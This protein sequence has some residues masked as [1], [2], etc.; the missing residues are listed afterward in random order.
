[1]KARKNDPPEIAI[2]M[3]AVE[4]V[5]YVEQQITFLRAKRRV[6]FRQ[7]AMA[8]LDANRKDFIYEIDKQ[9]RIMQERTGKDMLKH[10]NINPHRVQ[11]FSITEI[12]KFLEQRLIELE[13][14]KD[15]D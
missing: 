13:V 8:I 4:K 15:P 3:L 9:D 14:M 2:R 5:R 7:K 6:T 1:M 12:W 11:M 10:T